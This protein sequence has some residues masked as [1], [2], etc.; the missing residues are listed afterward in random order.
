[1]LH[2]SSYNIAV[3]VLRYSGNQHE[4][5]IDTDEKNQQEAVDSS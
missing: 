2:C 4:T 3:L 1:M 5:C